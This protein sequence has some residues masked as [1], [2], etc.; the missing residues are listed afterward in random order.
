[1]D[2]D[3]MALR[4]ILDDAFVAA[5]RLVMIGAATLALVATAIGAAIRSVKG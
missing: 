3:E 1:V 4:L 2:L 5:F